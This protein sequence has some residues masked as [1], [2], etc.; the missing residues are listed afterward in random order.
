MVG[1]AP[2]GTVPASGLHALRVPDVEKGAAYLC[3]LYNSSMFQE[4]A[5]AFPPGQLRSRDLKDLGV[6]DIGEV[7][8]MQVVELVEGQADLV[9]EMITD[10]A[11]L[12]PELR[13]GLLADNTLAGVPSG[14]WICSPG[15]RRRG[16]RLV[17][18]PGLGR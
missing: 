7:Q 16:E 8:R 5:E 17:R 15:A 14:A 11:P 10:L 1:M 18:S 6:P 12:F 2:A 4:L 13:S 9:T 3:G